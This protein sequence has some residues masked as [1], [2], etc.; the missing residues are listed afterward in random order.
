[1]D[2]AGGLRPGSFGVVL[3]EW[4]DWLLVNGLPE[5]PKAVG[6]GEAVPV[7]VWVGG[8]WAATLHLEYRDAD[9]HSDDAPTLDTE[10]QAYRWDGAEW[11]AVDGGGG[12]NWPWGLNLERPPL[13]PREAHAGSVGLYGG[14]E[15]TAGAVEGVA[16][17]AAATVEVECATGIEVAPLTSPIGAWVVAFDG[18]L[19]SIVRVRDADGLILCETFVAPVAD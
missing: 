8:R 11:E 18:R 16:G 6:E 19:D 2:E 7:A 13:A 12:S 4:D 3:G 10:K 14:P 1:M 15:W 5:L 9:D 17:T